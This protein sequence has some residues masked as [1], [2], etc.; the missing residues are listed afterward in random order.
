MIDRRLILALLSASLCLTLA[1]DAGVLIPSTVKKQPDPAILSL[2]EMRVSIVVDHR[3]ARVRLQQIYAS[4]LGRILEGTYLFS[5]PPGA[6]LSDFA[7]WDG[8]VR[9]PGVILEKRK[10][11]EIYRDLVWQSIDPG[12]LQMGGQDESSEIPAD[13]FTVKVVPIPPFGFKRMELE[14]QQRLDVQDG[15]VQFTLPLKS[16]LFAPL[17]ARRLAVDVEITEGRAIQDFA[18]TAP[19]YPVEWKERS[20]TRCSGSFRG[21]KVLLAQDFGFS[22][23]HDTTRPEG[24]FL[25]FRG[26]EGDVAADRPLTVGDTGERG[27]LEDGYFLLDHLLP[28]VPRTGTRPPLSVAIVVDTSLSMWWDKI[29]Q[30]DEAIREVFFVLGPEDE[31]NL[32]LFNDSVRSA[33]PKPVPATD[34]NR[35]AALEFFYKAFLSGGTDPVPAITEGLRQAG[36]GLHPA[37]NLILIGDWLP[38]TG[39]VKNADV[40][41]AVEPLLAKQGVQVGGILTGDDGNRPLL[42]RLALLTGGQALWLGSRED[43]GEDITRF[44]SRLGREPFKEL[45]LDCPESVFYQVYPAHPVSVF[46]ASSADWVGRY[47][48]SDAEV[49]LTLRGKDPAGQPFRLPQTVRLPAE[50]RSHPLLPRLWARARV[51]FLLDKINR[52]GEDKDSIQEIIALAQKYKF[53]TPYTSFLAAPRSLLRP[54]VIQ[55]M[56]P[57]IRIEADPGIAAATVVLPWGETLP[58]SFLPDAGCWQARFFAPPDLADG[59]HRCLVMLRDHDGRLFRE[60][61]SFVIDSRPPAVRWLNP[62]PEVRAGAELRLEVDAPPDTR[63]LSASLG[64]WGRVKLRW[65]VLRKCCTGVLPVASAVPPGGGRLILVAEDLAH[66]VFRKDYTVR[67]LP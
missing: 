66:N 2:E 8:V 58:M 35:Q 28:G 23:R 44:T 33:F 61:K 21:E 46:A 49:A 37:R 38:T 25:A 65:D 63:S 26:R 11:A 50:D 64:G 42:E 6:S 51:D 62:V 20:D 40:L 29:D 67:I 47:R 34:A 41:K 52:D 1:A 12:L 43:T 53:V 36:L 7:I 39:H 16:Q 10:A 9:I 24:N 55:P 14:Y 60:D 4:H 32:S 17:S 19:I 3:L 13:F 5:F 27:Q 22:W 30:A 54:R 56:D 45:V 31:F 48:P 18:L 57:V 59:A 15:K